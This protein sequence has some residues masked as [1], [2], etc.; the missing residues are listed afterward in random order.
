[1]SLDLIWQPSLLDAGPDPGVDEQFAGAVRVNL[2]RRSWIE[3]VPGWVSGSDAF[4]AHLLATAGW[5]KRTRKMWENEVLEPR[6]P[7]GWGAETGKPLEPPIL[8]RMRQAL[9]A[10]YGVEF[11]SMG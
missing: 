7:T 6:L 3:R 10:R 9:S 5:G 4:F 1:M 2:D 8:E 11:D